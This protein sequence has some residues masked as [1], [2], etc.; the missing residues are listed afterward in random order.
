MLISSNKPTISVD[1]IVEMKRF[2]QK[3]T[4]SRCIGLVLRFT[5]KCKSA[6]RKLEINLQPNLNVSEVEGAETALI[7]SIQ[8]ESFANEIH[9]LSR[10]E[11]IRKTMKA[12]LYL[13]QFN[14]NLDENYI[15]HCR[16]RI[17]HSIVPDFWTKE[18]KL[19]FVYKRK[20]K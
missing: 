18:I 7:R 1:E 4:L 2:S 17:G 16:S 10:I 5:S 13:K 3:D 8:S 11:S 6:I 15:V 20:S 12:P 9:C 14:L 19:D